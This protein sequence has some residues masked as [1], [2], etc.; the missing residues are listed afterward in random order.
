MFFEQFW[1][2]NEFIKSFY[3]F[4]LKIV[5]DLPSGSISDF[6]PWGENFLVPFKKQREQA[7]FQYIQ[8]AVFQ[9]ILSFS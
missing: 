9:Y 5:I 4:C 2:Q 7:V 8:Q 3:H 6:F 1:F